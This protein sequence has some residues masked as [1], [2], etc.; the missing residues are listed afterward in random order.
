MFR[1]EFILDIL[2]LQMR[3]KKKKD[4][5]VDI[6]N[7]ETYTKFIYSG[8][9]DKKILGGDRL[10]KLSKGGDLKKEFRETLA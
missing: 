6:S 1:D 8:V 10:F 5:W 9:A 3:S 4:L 7:V 2:D